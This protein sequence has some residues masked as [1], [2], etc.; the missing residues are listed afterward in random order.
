MLLA[1]RQQRRFVDEIR[2]IG[3]GKSRRALRNDLEIHIRRHL[4][5]ARVDAQNLLAAA[6]VRLVHQHLAIEAARSQQRGI[7]HFGPVRRAHDDDPLAGIETVH[8]R[9]KLV[10][11]L[12][13]LFVAAHRALHAHLAERVEL[14]NEHDAGRLRLG[15]AE[16]IAHAR[17][18]D[19]DE[20]LHEFRSAEAEKGHLGFAGDGFGQQRLAGSRR[21]DQQNPLRNAAADVR[22]FLRVLQELDDLFQLVLRLI[23]PRDI[24]EAHLDI[25][26]GVDFRAAPGERHDAAFGAAHSTEEK[27]PHRD[28][29]QQ[30]NDPAQQ[31]R[32]PAV[33][34]LAGVL[35]TRFLE[36][37]D[38][39]RILDSR[40][41]KRFALG[42]RSGSFQSAADHLFADGRF[43]DLALLEPET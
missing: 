34:H 42:V 3:A 11:R 41:A 15:L 24:A 30:R 2:E 28:E 31:L 7:E 10:E 14:V 9:E 16:E 13:A 37:G 20:H 1:R 39:R 27:A 25:V 26:F 43:G 6:H 19:A 23:D 40:C 4:H 18:A 8:L 12:L 5:R 36:L 32:K 17:R 21:A 33:H 29:Q 35:H 22:V 38:Q